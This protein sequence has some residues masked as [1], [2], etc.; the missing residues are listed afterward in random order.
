MVPKETDLPEAS[1]I[2][3]MNS[4]WITNFNASLLFAAIFLSMNFLKNV[5]HGPSMTTERYSP[6]MLKS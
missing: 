2:K 1:S 6:V 3:F 4:T 5:N